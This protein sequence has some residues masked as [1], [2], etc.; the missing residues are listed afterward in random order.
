VNLLQL[1][2]VKNYLQIKFILINWIRI[3]PDS[4]NSDRNSIISFNYSNAC[5]PYSTRLQIEELYDAYCLHRRLRDGASKM[6]KAYT[7][8]HLSKEARESLAEANKG[9]KEY[10]EVKRRGQRRGEEVD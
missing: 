8:S 9:Y 6:V 10:T 2:E 1:I 4:S 3:G 5:L 7:A